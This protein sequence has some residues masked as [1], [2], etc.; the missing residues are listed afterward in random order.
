MNKQARDYYKQAAVN[1][2]IEVGDIVLTG[3]YKNKRKEV[4]EL[5]TDE[6]GQPTV[7]GMK[8]LAV[9]IEKAMPKNKQ[10]RKTQ[11]LSKE[12][13]DLPG[14][15][16]RCD[17]PIAN[18][19]THKET[20]CDECADIEKEARD[21]GVSYSCAM[22]YLEDAD[23]KALTNWKKDMKTLVIPK[24]D[25]H[26]YGR[27]SDPHVTVLYGIHTT[28]ANKVK[29][30]LKKGDRTMMTVRMG[31]LAIFEND[32]YD[33]LIRK[34]E[35]KDHLKEVR[36]TL[37][38]NLE[39]TVTFPDYKPHAT[40]AYLKKGKGKEYL[41][42]YKDTKWE[43]SG[44]F[45]CST[46]DFSNKG[47]KHTKIEL[48]ETKEAGEESAPNYRPAEDTAKSCG[49]CSHSREGYCTL[50]DFDA[51]PQYT[52]DSFSTDITAQTPDGVPQVL[53]KYLPKV[54]AYSNPYIKDIEMAHQT[55]ELPNSL[56]QLLAWLLS[57]HDTN[58]KVKAYHGAVDT[59]KEAQ[60]LPYQTTAPQNVQTNV[61]NPTAATSAPQMRNDFQ[62]IVQQGIKDNAARTAGAK[63]TQPG[64][65]VAKPSEDINT[66][67]QPAKGDINAAAKPYGVNNTGAQYGVNTASPMEV[68]A[69]APA[70]M[71][72]IPA[73][74][75]YAANPI[76]RQTGIRGIDTVRNNKGTATAKA[77]LNAAA[78]H[79][80]QRLGRE[81]QA[82]QMQQAQQAQQQQAQMQHYAKQEE[83]KSAS[84]S[85]REG[86]MAKLAEMFN[87]KAV[88]IP[89][90]NKA[91][92]I[93]LSNNKKQS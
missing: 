88:A 72:Q 58:Q 52:C 50:F 47:E 74:A 48:T 40:I 64:Q 2:D 79:N 54:A 6:L 46:I 87:K 61:N 24:E 35:R 17:E 33:V 13:K 34:V 90:A 65:D 57:R 18:D 70:P 15:C 77:H 83:S 26:E 20:L 76:A 12:A 37:M 81:A 93:A 51:D 44:E 42:K 85:Y 5:G 91:L 39:A 66:V 78:R 59:M 19:D 4:T 84:A 11:E 60:A 68:Q 62:S 63:A 1:L 92:A 55:K 22:L 75:P 86:Y 30:A 41:K 31:D 23:S 73:N 27:E 8:L 80:A 71:M 38:D 9:R 16:D 29:A 43:L 69:Q 49:T 21:G 89:K 28:S 10:S 56:P 45:D 53:K 14:R 3:R 82:R 32:D 67:G 7:N 25:L 36:K